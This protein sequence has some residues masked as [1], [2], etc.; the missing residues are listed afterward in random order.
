MQFQTILRKPSYD[1]GIT[2]EFSI[3]KD[4]SPDVISLIA[5]ERTMKRKSMKLAAMITASMI[6][7]STVGCATTQDASVQSEETGTEDSTETGTENTQDSTAAEVVATSTSVVSEEDGS[8]LRVSELF[9]ERD[10]E[11]EADLTNAETLT[12]KSGEDITITEEGVY[13]VS[14]QVENSTIYVE[15]SEDAKIQIV[16]DKVSITN[17]SMPAIY[18]KSGDKVFITTTDSENTL[19]VTGSYVAD[20]DT[21]L[22]AVIF[23]KSDITVNGVGAL[24]IT[25]DTGNGITSKDDLIITGGSIEITAAGDGLEANDAICIYDGILTINAGKDAIHSENEENTSTG[26]FYM[27]SAT[28]NLTAGDDG[29]QAN[30]INQIDGGIITITS[31]TEGI[32]GTYVQINGGEITIN[33]S[34]DG[35][36]AT[37]KSEYDVLLEVN[38]GTISVVMGAGDTDAFDSN[39]AIVINGGT[40]TIEGMSAFDSDG[41][42]TLNGGDVTVNGEKITEI[43]Q[44]QMGGGRGGNGGFIKRGF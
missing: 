3:T 32:E 7:L 42:A 20:G 26:H 1:R 34:D 14:G 4:R 11:Q 16:L 38:G 40:I 36:N 15:A 23:S 17:E 21:N 35:I 30:A 24:D 5:K 33:A 2:S 13:V 10:L 37:S 44:M 6:I 31:A 22:D 25:S 28:L 12:L 27:R 43:T 41:T 9:S 19:K 39:G 29:I 8:A 18:I